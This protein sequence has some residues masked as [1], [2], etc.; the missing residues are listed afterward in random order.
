M[1][2]DTEGRR[3]THAIPRAAE[4]PV[5]RTPQALVSATSHCT[6]SSWGEGG[7]CLSHSAGPTLQTQDHSAHQSTRGTE[8]TVVAGGR[9][10]LCFPRDQ[11]THK[12]LLVT[13][14][15]LQTHLAAEGVGQLYRREI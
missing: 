10:V 2:L 12:P 13:Q 6:G 7:H 5:P 15:P 11:L 14:G 8:R 4:P 9:E 3:Q 1:A